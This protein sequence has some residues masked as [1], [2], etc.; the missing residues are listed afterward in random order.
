MSP[1]FA[2]H[3]SPLPSSER[4]HVLIVHNG[5]VDDADVVGAD[6]DVISRCGEAEDEVVDVA[7]AVC[8]VLERAG[9]GVERLVLSSSTEPLSRRLDDGGVDVVFNLVES[10]A[11]DAAR[12]PEVPALLTSRGVPYTGN[13]PHVLERAFAKDTIRDLLS[14]AAVPIPRGIVVTSAASAEALLSSSTL[15][16]PLFVKP[17]RIDGSIGIDQGSVVK[18]H[19]ALLARVALLLRTFAGPVLVEEYLPGHEVNV[20]FCPGDDGDAFAPT[21]LDFHGFS[22]EMW[23]VVTYAAKW[24]E[25][26]PDY[27]CRS[28]PVG[29][30][31][32]RAVVDD[33]IAIA[34]SAL[35]AVGADAYAR[36]DLRLDG[37][38]RPAV[39]D[40]NPNPALHPEAGLALGLSSVGMSFDDVVTAIIRHARRRSSCSSD[41]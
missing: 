39:I 34:R 31:L 6:V 18:D 3:V 35:A 20:A 14:D 15:R 10:L 40:V 24:V 4:C 12:E 29:E 17:A 13:S 38:G 25:G 11:G 27:N 32:P 1:P 19:T 23:P 26:S 5:T 37:D 8:A 7:D 22:A 2:A 28:L 33:V 21:M 30:R 16:Y 41:T 9:F 36:V